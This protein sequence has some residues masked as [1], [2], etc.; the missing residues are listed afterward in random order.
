MTDELQFLSLIS[1]K[2]RSLEVDGDGGAPEADPPELKPRSINLRPRPQ[3]SDNDLTQEKPVPEF[4]SIFD[5]VIAGAGA[6]GLALAAA[7]K[8]VMGAGAAV[9]VV[10]PAKAPSP[11]ADAKSI[12]TVAIAEGP[13]RLLQS[14]GAWQ[15][16]EPKTQAILS[17]AIMDGG[18]A[19]AVRLAHL[20]FEA[21]GDGPLAHM[22]FSDDVV[23][24]LSALCDSLGRRAYRGVGR[25]LGPSQARR[26][27]R[28]FRR[29][30]TAD[31]SCR[32][33]RRSALETA[34]ARR[35]PDHR[36]GLRS[37]RHRRD[38]RA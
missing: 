15:T 38:H 11:E 7:V 20:N 10:D 28:A 33:R 24:T 1:Q 21:K 26:R 30:R 6:S 8:Q 19:D 22:A 29:A 27:Y 18:V 34:G 13:R 17:M 32:R 2:S 4:A 31:P 36:L 37:G 12:R 16:L 3:T 5:I 9:A 23:W 35:H 14:V 25:A